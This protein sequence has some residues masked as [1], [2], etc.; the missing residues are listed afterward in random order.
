MGT[1]LARINHKIRHERAKVQAGRGL[2][3]DL[4]VKL[5]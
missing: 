5:G 3:A 2:G 1:D 4:R